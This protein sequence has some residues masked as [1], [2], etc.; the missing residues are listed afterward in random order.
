MKTTP[1]NKLIQSTTGSLKSGD[2]STVISSVST[3]TRNIGE[4]CAF[5]ALKGERFDAH[6]FLDK[7]I[8][9]GAKTL[10]VSHI[11]EGI[12]LDGVAVVLVGNTLSALQQF[13]AWYRR[14]LDISVVGVTG[15]NGKTSTKDFAK[16]VLAVKL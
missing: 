8:A 7:A 14:D 6:D 9:G 5:F 16:S 12:N 11:P 15:S 3:D 10:V 2:E 13:A 1:L 4:D